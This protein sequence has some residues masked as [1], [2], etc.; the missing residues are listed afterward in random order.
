MEIKS[1]VWVN[2]RDFKGLKHLAGLVGDRFQTGIVVYT[3]EQALDGFGGKN[4]Q[5]VPISNL[6]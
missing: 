6:W 2:K 4:L 5:A 1:K 3:G